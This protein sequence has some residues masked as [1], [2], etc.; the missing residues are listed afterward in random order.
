MF[1]I[2]DAPE[3]IARVM[4]AHGAGAPMD[5]EWMNA[6]TAL[7]VER[8]LSVARFEFSFMAAM[9]E[10]AKR[11][12]APRGDKVVPEY[13]VAVMTLG[14]VASDGLPLLIGGKSLG[15]RVAT[16]AAEE[17]YASGQIKGVAALGY[18][19]HP[20]GK[21][22]RLRTAHLQQFDCPALI[23]QG[24]RDLLGGQDEVAGYGLDE[25]IEIVWCADGDHDLKPR[26]RSGET[27][28][29]HMARAADAVA[30]FAA[31]VI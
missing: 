19:F 20:R 13:V 15:G 26:K 18:P 30:G 29:G 28:E 17:L 5:H 10:G 31:R 21:P 11:R 8:R 3:P 9:R 14:G 12:P 16:L 2:D 24:T 4:L 6:M 25:R 27:L 1:L 23:V 7:L 22:E